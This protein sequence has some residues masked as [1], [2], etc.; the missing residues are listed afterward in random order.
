M[1]KNKKLV[2][3]FLLACCVVLHFYAKNRDAELE[4][5]MQIGVAKVIAVR[6]SYRYTRIQYEYTIEGKLYETSSK[7]YIIY[8]KGKVY[9]NKF[10]PIVYSSENPNRSEI[11]ALPED[12]KKYSV[13]LPDSLY[14]IRNIEK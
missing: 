3:I 12:Y 13:A 7:K 14:W 2:I 6:P 4:N 5:N 8:T 11:L 10:L 1:S 9:S